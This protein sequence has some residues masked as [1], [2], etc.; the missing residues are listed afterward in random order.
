M[1]NKNILFVLAHLDDETFGLGGYLQRLAKSDTNISF[2]FLCSGRDDENFFNR[3]NSFNKV[4]DTLQFKNHPTYILGDSYD[5]ELEKN[6]TKDIC[7]F[8]ENMIN[9][10]KPDIII[11]NA[12]TDMHQDHIITSE[13][14]KIAAR[15]T[16]HKVKEIYELRIP[17]SEF[18][19]SSYFDVVIELTEDELRLKK[20]LSSFYE[21]EKPPKFN[22]FEYLRTVY[23][24][25]D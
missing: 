13:A 22:N 23:R 16:R 6:F 17:E 10:K 21:T 14:V 2:M 8:I 5:M 1:Y 9:E 24:E 25:L 12:E 11:T 19:K 3:L 4:I 20:F 18:F 15:P 7:S